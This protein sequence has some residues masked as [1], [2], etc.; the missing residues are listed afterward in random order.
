MPVEEEP[1]GEVGRP[2]GL[3]G[4][5]VANQQIMDVIAASDSFVINVREPGW[6]LLPGGLCGVP[7]CGG[8]LP[9]ANFTSTA[10]ISPRTSPTML[11]NVTPRDENL[12]EYAHVCFVA[13]SQL[14][15]CRGLQTSVA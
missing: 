10:G 14:P 6:S 1:Q 4:A 11:S 12:H 13:K 5:D 9:T 3:D 8:R 15:H 2:A 7:P